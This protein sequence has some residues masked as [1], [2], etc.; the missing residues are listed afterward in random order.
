MRIP[1]LGKA[2]LV[3]VGAALCLLVAAAPGRA[4]ADA[5]DRAGAASLPSAPRA[6][7]ASRPAGVI[8]A[9]R[10]AAAKAATSTPS[11][12][13]AAYL[14]LVTDLAADDMEGRGPGTKGIDKARDYIAEH[15]KA[16]G[17]AGAFRGSYTE[18]FDATIGVTARQQALAILDSRGK[19]INDSAGGVAFNTMGI[20]ANGAFSAPAVFV[21]YAI[22]DIGRKY[23]SFHDLPKDGLKGKVAVAL[24]YEPM[25][26][27]QSKWEKSPGA[28]S[29]SAGL[30]NKANAA[31]RRGAVALL[32][33]DPPGKR[34]PLMST[35]STGYG[36]K[37]PIP[38]LHISEEFFEQ[39]LTAGG[40]DAAKE[41]DLM[42]ACA[43]RGDSRCVE[44]KAI[45]VRGKASVE[46]VRGK[47]Y[48]VAAVLPGAGE[49]ASQVIVVGGHY[50][51][52]G[53]SPGQ[54]LSP[55]GGPATCAAAVGGEERKTGGQEEG[56]TSM[57]F[58]AS[59]SS[60]P[61]LSSSR[62]SSFHPAVPPSIYHGADDN[63]SGTAGV[64]TMAQWMADLAA[65]P[66][67]APANR[68]TI[69]FVTFSGE[70]RGLLGSQ[71]LVGH[72][73]DMGIKREQVVAMLN[74][75]MIGRV[76]G[77]AAFIF[78]ADSG[79]Q[80]RTILAELT[81]LSPLKITTG[82]SGAGPSD[83][84]SFY[85]ARVPVLH[86]FSGAQG[87][88]HTPR[89]TAD[90]INAAGAI[91]MLQLGKAVLLRLWEEPKAIAYKDLH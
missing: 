59:S 39:L 51:H 86:F 16:A 37:C 43:D 75:D 88:M 58:A 45:T 54:R 53:I 64:L 22:T 1:A 21:G 35:Q 67:R 14:R 44:L 20:S 78:G 60:P 2:A 62:L 46:P 55:A 18:P 65:D 90:K 63:A 19:V 57:K 79:D 91:D 7:D 84:A 49:L 6:M 8:L 11:A 32:I 42:S 5:G 30:V 89:D 40:L 36:F 74:F 85:A 77:S 26:D 10:P 83:H 56:R 23:D 15:F 31:A 13:A 34:G 80:W 81:P 9:T 68:R 33:V 76:R 29:Q 61:V 82:S 38:M 3:M 69:V 87:D 47:L 52:I 72:L 4:R 71:Y 17:L 66:S 50:D 24:R 25:E 12:E 70:E 28:W 27:G 73:A 48:N 41:I